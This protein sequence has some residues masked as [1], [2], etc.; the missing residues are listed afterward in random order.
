MSDEEI[1]IEAN[2]DADAGQNDDLSFDEADGQIA[3]KFKKLQAELKACDE[4]RREYL[5]GWQRAKADYINLKKDLDKERGDYGR[6]AR[7]SVLHEL[8]PLADSFEL[9]FANKTAWQEAPANWRQGVEYIYQQLQSIFQHYGLEI[10][11]PLHQPF[12][13]EQHESLG[14]IAGEE[15]DEGRVLEVLKK[16]YILGGKVLRPAQVKVGEVKGN[17]KS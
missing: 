15:T 16:G 3:D 2:S 9:A 7:E 17:P 11:D 12:N 1:K 8:L 4:E 10:I 14:F 6:L 5:A 13:P